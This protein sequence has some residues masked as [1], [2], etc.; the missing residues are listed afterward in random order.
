M[1][2]F[3][4]HLYKSYFS[5]SRRRFNCS[6]KTTNKFSREKCGKSRAVQGRS[7][8]RERSPVSHEKCGTW[9]RRPEKSQNFARRWFHRK[10]ELTSIAKMWLTPSRTLFHSRALIAIYLSEAILFIKKKVS[11]CLKPVN[12]EMIC[13]KRRKNVFPFFFA[14]KIIDKYNDTA[15]ILA[16]ATSLN[17][18][19]PRF[20]NH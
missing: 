13:E 14:E 4:R 5:I 16:A 3:N 8:T 2:R 15:L 9:W 12:F 10:N 6:R 1:G 19:C 11:L 7:V 20:H 18:P 17:H